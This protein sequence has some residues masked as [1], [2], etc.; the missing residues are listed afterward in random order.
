MGFSYQMVT[1]ELNEILEITGLMKTAAYEAG[2]HSLNG[3]EELCKTKIGDFKAR[4]KEV[5][6]LMTALDNKIEYLGHQS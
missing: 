4:A 3:N 1:K 6:K 5:S 2:L